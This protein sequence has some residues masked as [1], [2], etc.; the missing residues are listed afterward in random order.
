M[1]GSNKKNLLIVQI[2]ITMKTNTPRGIKQKGNQLM[3][4]GMEIKQWTLHKVAFLVHCFQVKLEF[5][6]FL[7]RGDGPREKPSKQGQEPTTNSTHMWCHVHAGMETQVIVVGDKCSNLLLCHPYSLTINPK[8]D[9]SWYA[10]F[11]TTKKH[12]NSN[13]NN[14]LSMLLNIIIILP[15]TIY[16]PISWCLFQIVKWLLSNIT[17]SYFDSKLFSLLALGRFLLKLC[18][19]VKNSENKI[20]FN[21]IH[22]VDIVYITIVTI[23]QLNSTCLK[24][25]PNKFSILH[26]NHHHHHISD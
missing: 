16:L 24:S 19:T 14:K 5:E 21:Q 4:M 2:F 12:N 13:N 3:R 11:S 10:H 23:T 25:K 8:R 17:L 7:P 22:T 9:F 20:E 6:M 18:E 15:V 26:H 1:T